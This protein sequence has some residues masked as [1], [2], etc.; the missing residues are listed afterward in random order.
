MNMSYCRFQNT[1][2]D[3][4]DC[5]DNLPDG[6]LSH[7]EAAAFAQIV[8]LAKDIAETYEDLDYYQLKDLAIENYRDEQ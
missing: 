5:Y 8:A 7:A 3:L 1:L 2:L 6:N 4:Q